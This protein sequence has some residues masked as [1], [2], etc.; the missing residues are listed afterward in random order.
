MEGGGRLGREGE[1]DGGG[2]K[3]SIELFGRLTDVW[4][5]LEVCSVHGLAKGCIEGG[6]S[7]GS[8]SESH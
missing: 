5:T 4:W 7:T 8:L 3:K 1:R 6:F 2:L